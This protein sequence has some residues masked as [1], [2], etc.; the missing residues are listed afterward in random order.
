M[1]NI[2]INWNPI[3][4]QVKYSRSLPLWGLIWKENNLSGVTSRGLV[5]RVIFSIDQCE[6]GAHVLEVAF[7]LIPKISQ[8]VKLSDIETYRWLSGSYAVIK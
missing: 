3:K 7:P 5:S 8:P 6:A 4:S 2:F 1:D